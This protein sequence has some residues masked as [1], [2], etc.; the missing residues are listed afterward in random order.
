MYVLKKK[1]SWDVD[2]TRNRETV[3]DLIQL[4][5]ESTIC[6]GES[7][8]FKVDYAFICQVSSTSESSHKTSKYVQVL[9]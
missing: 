4:A 2:M 3:E 1:S 5:K 6:L 8:F 9:Q 7:N